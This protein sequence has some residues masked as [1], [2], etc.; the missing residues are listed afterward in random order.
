[1]IVQLNNLTLKLGKYWQYQAIVQAYKNIENANL[2]GLYQ[3]FILLTSILVILDK[4]K[5]KIEATKQTKP[6]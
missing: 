6:K 4:T 5:N 1:M 2:N 3:A